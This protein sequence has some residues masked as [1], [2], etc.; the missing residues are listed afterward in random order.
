MSCLIFCLIYDDEV[1][2]YIFEFT[3]ANLYVSKIIFSENFDS[4]IESTQMKTPAKPVN[5][6]YT[7][8]LRKTIPA[9]TGSKSWNHEDFFNRE[10]IQRLALAMATN[11][12]FLGSKS[13][14]PFS[15]TKTQRKK[16]QSVWKWLIYCRNSSADRK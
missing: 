6:R 16:H 8:I 1:K 15:F 7:E 13:K 12:A 2:N 9:S 3:Q 14:K 5:G 10:P 11:K 4:A